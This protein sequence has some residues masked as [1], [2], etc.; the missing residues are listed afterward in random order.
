MSHPL[1]GVALYLN[2][3]LLRLTPDLA[4]DLGSRLYNTQT[5]SIYVW[6]KAF[7]NNRKPLLKSCIV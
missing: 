2:R 4:P 6:L 3:R 7:L 1:S 5:G